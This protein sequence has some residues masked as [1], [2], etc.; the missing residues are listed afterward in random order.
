M[1][2]ERAGEA[3]MNAV[4]VAPLRSPNQRVIWQ[5]VFVEYVKG[6]K[7]FYKDMTVRIILSAKV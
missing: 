4:A 3:R 2:S 5:L 7:T 1:E 6:S